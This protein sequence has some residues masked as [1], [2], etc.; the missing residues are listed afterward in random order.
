MCS[1]YLV[2]PGACDSAPAVP[3]ST[4][5]TSTTLVCLQ[6][7]AAE[8]VL[9]SCSKAVG[10]DGGI[11]SLDSSLR[12]ELE[13]TTTDMA[14][15]GLRTLCITYRDF[16]SSAGLPADSFETPPDSELICCAITGIKASCCLATILQKCLAFT[17]THDR[18]HE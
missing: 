1:L 13:C 14:A 16:P 2:S 3:A 6:Q 10:A 8:I 4:Y 15:R 7:G 11:I 18:Y 17:T 9:K 12:S 5:V